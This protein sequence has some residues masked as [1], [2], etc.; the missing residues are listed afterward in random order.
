MGRR[1]VTEGEIKNPKN[2]KKTEK[3]KKA[4]GRRWAGSERG[5]QGKNEHFIWKEKNFP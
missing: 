4:G 1:L 3:W 2:E 5:Q